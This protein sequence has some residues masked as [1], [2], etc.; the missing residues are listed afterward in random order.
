MANSVKKEK[1]KGGWVAR[2][3][4]SG[5]FVSVVSGT[6]KS[7][8]SAKTGEVVKEASEKRGNALKR[9]ADR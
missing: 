6:S 1:V 4:E 3:T 9:L 8:R 5:R 7:N 2:H